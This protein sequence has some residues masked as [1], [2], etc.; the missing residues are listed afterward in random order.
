MDENKLGNKIIEYR[1]Q[2][3]LSQKELAEM[4]GVSNK[5]VSKWE[6]GESMPKM[7]T[8]IKL[9]EIFNIDVNDLVGLTAKTSSEPDE[10]DI[11]LQ[12]LKSENERLN[13]KLNEA[14]K[15][16]KS[17][18][19]ISVVVCIIGVIIS[20]IIAF[21]ITADKGIN[22]K[23]KDAGKANTSIEF[24]GITFTP[25]SAL[26]KYILDSEDNYYYSEEKYAD[27]VDTNGVKQKAVIKCDRS[28]S[29]YVLLEVNNKKFFYTN[30]NDKF[31]WFNPN[32]F[33]GFD[34]I[35]KS[36]A[37]NGFFA[38]DYLRSIYYDDY[39]CKKDFCSFYND[40]GNPV[41]SSITKNFL[42]NKGATVSISFGFGWN[43]LTRDIGEFFKD[44]KGNVYFYDYV[45]NSAYSVREELSKRVY[46]Y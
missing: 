36:V 40:K 20:A 45:T 42:G 3:A 1:K 23:I 12:K 46:K 41:D 38:T 31:G 5:A 11:E 10:K 25:A 17:T 24:S 22:L 43:Y 2:Q 39:Y 35:G 18:L 21:T 37:V 32:N 28:V 27:F 8:M 29:E 19:V 13:L 14:S 4:V 16:T 34:L 6:N 30:F 33:D 44:D 26:D 9:A 15:K 7:S